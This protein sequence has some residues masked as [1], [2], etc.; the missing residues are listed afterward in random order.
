[1]YKYIYFTVALDHIF[2]MG[3]S[4]FQMPWATRLLHCL[5]LIFL[6][7]HPCPARNTRVVLAPSICQ[8]ESSEI[9]GRGLS[10]HSRC[11]KSSNGLRLLVP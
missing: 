8:K 11:H 4:G 1:M 9:E 10:G 2:S 3:K 5:Q 7:D 6:V